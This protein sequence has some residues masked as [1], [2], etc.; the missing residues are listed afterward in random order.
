MKNKLNVFI[1]LY[2]TLF[3]LFFYAIGNISPTYASEQDKI[4]YKS[5]TEYDYPPF[6]VITDGK[7]DGFSVELLKAV[8]NEMELEIEFKV[9][10]WNTIKKELEDGKL[11]ILPL[12]GYSEERDEYF[13]FTVP[14]IVMRGNIFVR[15]DYTEIESEED[16]YGKE[17]IVMRSDNSQE[18]AEMMDFTDQLILVNTYAEAFELL[19]SGQHDAVL[20]QSLVGEKLINDLDIKNIEAVSRLADNGVDHLKIS[21]E[22]FEQKFTFAVK[23]GDKALLALLNEGLAIVSENGTYEALYVKWFPFLIDT[24]PDYR[25]IAYYFI[26]AL[27]VIIIALLLFS[28]LMIQKEVKRQTAKLENN[29]YRNT[30]MFNVMNKEYDSITDWLDYVLNELIKMTGS[31]FGYIYLVNEEAKELTLNSWSKGVMK[32]CRIAEKKTVYKLEN[33]IE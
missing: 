29:L 25:K 2:I 3:L 32:E 9:D 22:G 17:I 27:V 5:A 30:I 7:A 20:A 24:S 6:S 4:V 18:Y 15:K 33:I 14:Y 13:D 1:L 21:L 31:E 16:L 8:A 28:F 19:S 23:E 11:D 26:A 10:H 12:V